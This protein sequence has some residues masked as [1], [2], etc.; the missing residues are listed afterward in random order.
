MS[1]AMP[2]Q[3]GS[4]LDLRVRRGERVVHVRSIPWKMIADEAG[5][6]QSQTN[7]GQ[8]L[9]RIRERMGF[10]ATEAIC[11][12]AGL[13]FKDLQPISNETAHRILYAMVVLFNRGQ[14]IAEA[15]A[16]VWHP[17]VEAPKDGRWI[18][19]MTNDGVSLYRVRWGTD[20]HG[21]QYWCSADQVNSYGD[22]LFSGWTE[23]PQAG[24]TR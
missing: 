11:V 3:I 7:H 5:E 21:E 16:A 14:R 10:D 12:M 4:D 19:A 13:P 24:G 18:C 15:R 22:G 1:K 6:R 17:M 23:I 2:I 8:T 20:R 9:D